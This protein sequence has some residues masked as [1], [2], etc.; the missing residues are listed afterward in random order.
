MSLA[1]SIA[2]TALNIP[3]IYLGYW[4]H[5][6]LLDQRKRAAL[7]AVSGDLSAVLDRAT[8]LSNRLDRRDR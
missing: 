6:H 7:R 1:W 3:L 5:L 2:I 4:L 8:A